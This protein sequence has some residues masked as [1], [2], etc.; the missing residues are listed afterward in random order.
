M[1]VIRRRR[2]RSIRPRRCS[3]RSKLGVSCIFLLVDDAGL[4]L[5]C[6]G[7]PGHRGRFRWLNSPK[8]QAYCGALTHSRRDHRKRAGVPTDCN[9]FVES[10][11]KVSERVRRDAAPSSPTR[12]AAGGRA[13][14]SAREQNYS[15]IVLFWAPSDRA[16]AAASVVGSLPSLGPFKHA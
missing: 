10:T 7:L 14:S 9:K 1:P 11:A 4:H 12:G 3:G 16:S 8:T 15:V 6:P 2:L 13:R 5:C